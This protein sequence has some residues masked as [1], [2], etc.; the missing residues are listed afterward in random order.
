MNKFEL[1]NKVMTSDLKKEQKLLLIEVILRMD[2][3]K[4][5]FPGVKRLCQVLGIKH[6]KNFK[7]VESYLPPGFITVTKKGRKNFYTLNTPAV[8]GLSEASVI[9]K[10]TPN[11]NTPAVEGSNTPAVAEN[12][13]AVEGA[14]SSIDITGDNS[15]T[16]VAGAPVVLDDIFHLEGKDNSPSN[17]QIDEPVLDEENQRP[18]YRQ[19]RRHN[20]GKCIGDVTCP[21]PHPEM[22]GW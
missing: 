19:M 5:A 18:S 22:V 21:L 1:M 4:E 11:P 10:E 7:G 14:N 12:T 3:G 13:P 8:E 16:P 17:S 9:V 2:E 6:S 15:P 20:E